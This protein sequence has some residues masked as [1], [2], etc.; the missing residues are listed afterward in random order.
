MIPPALAIQ[1]NPA[2][3]TEIRLKRIGRSR[4]PILV[5][6]NVLSNPDEVRAWA[7]EL[8]FAPPITGYYPGYQA[9]AAIRGADGLAAW[10]A[11]YLLA[12]AY[13]FDSDEAKYVA[14]SVYVRTGFAALAPLPNYRYDSIHADGHSWLA[15]LI[16][17]KP[18]ADEF[19]ATGFWRHMPTGLEGVYNG[20]QPLMNSARFDRLLGT[21]LVEDT[22]RALADTTETDYMQWLR[23]ILSQDD[24]PFEGNDHGSWEKVDEVRSVYNR[25]VVYPTWQLHSVIEDHERVP[26][27]VEDARLTLNLFVRSPLFNGGCRV[28]AR[29]LQTERSTGVL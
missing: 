28:P 25:L 23:T 24:T 2:S 9:P 4:T 10:A 26:Q 19:S 15:G 13:D 5:V 20:E 11:E 17:L 16:Y 12:H 29:P 14:S 6:D 22:A 21:T 3:K 8:S 7:L 27:S 18:G 1:L